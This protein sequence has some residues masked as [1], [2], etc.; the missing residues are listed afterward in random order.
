MELGVAPGLT[1][2]TSVYHAAC[3]AVLQYPVCFCPFL[4]VNAVQAPI[5]KHFRNI[6]LY[7]TLQLM[8]FDD[9]EDG[10]LHPR[11][12]GAATPTISQLG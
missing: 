2:T 5:Q 7:N 1:I 8:S 9:R 4:S 12:L 3:A 6:P 10:F 11:T